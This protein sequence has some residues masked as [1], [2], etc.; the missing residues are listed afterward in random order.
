VKAD[1]LDMTVA[2]PAS[3]LSHSP[4]RSAWIARCRA[5]RDDEHAV[6]T[7]TAGPSSPKV[8]ATRPDATLPALPVAA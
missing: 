6:S 2:P 5:T 1:G 8:Y 4:L 3:A 7:V